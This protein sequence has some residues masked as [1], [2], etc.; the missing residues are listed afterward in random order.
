[1]TKGVAIGAT[2]IGEVLG[3]VDGGFHRDAIYAGRLEATLDIDTQTAFGWDGGLLHATGYQLH[4]RGLSYCC[5]N[6]LLPVSNIEA[7]RETRL[8]T[9]WAQQSFADGQASLRV[10]QIAADD[11]FFT[12]KVAAPF[13]NGTFGWPTLMVGNT[14]GGA[15][16]FPIAAPG[17][18]LQVAADANR[19]ILAG[20]FAGDPAGNAN[21]LEPEFRNRDGLKFSLSGGAF[22]IVEAQYNIT[23]DSDPDKTPA[24]YKAG[25]WV[26][27]GDRALDMFGDPGK[28]GPSWGAYAIVERMVWQPDGAAPDTGLSVFARVGAGASDPQPVRFYVDAGLNY[29]GPFDRA[30]DMVGIALAYN[31]VSDTLRRAD[32]AAGLP[33][34]ESESVIELTYQYAAASWLV[35]QPDL[36]YV[37]RPGGGVLDPNVPT[38]RVPNATVAGLRT[39]LRF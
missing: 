30:D 37:I 33:A 5:L 28:R 32:R 23:P 18:R 1:M 3:V 6:N 38:R 17:V 31:K 24:S 35:V 34:R 36:Q 21:G 12:S 16:A 15:A 39:T 8:F 11:E 20:I 22:A 9:L 7:R 29:R 27:T 25:L 13:I 19:Q 10:G 26:Q 14:P 2:Y 4:G